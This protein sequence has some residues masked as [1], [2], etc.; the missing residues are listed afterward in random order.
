MFF[1]V[2]GPVFEEYVSL[3][4]KTSCSGP[5]IPCDRMMEFNDVDNEGIRESILEDIESCF[6]IEGIPCFVCETL[7]LNNIV[8]EVLLLHVKLL[9]LLL[10]LRLDGSISIHISELSGDSLP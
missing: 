5:F 9:K 1:S 4:L 10:G 2:L 6:F 7:K 8:V 3:V